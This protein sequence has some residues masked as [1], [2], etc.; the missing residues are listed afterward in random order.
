MIQ[1]LLGV[2]S[3]Q[4]IAALLDSRLKIADLEG[5]TFL[6]KDHGCDIRSKPGQFKPHPESWFI[7][8]GTKL[9]LNWEFRIL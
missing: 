8:N 6:Q 5:P 4:G 3:I 9:A 1:A 7:G 2:S